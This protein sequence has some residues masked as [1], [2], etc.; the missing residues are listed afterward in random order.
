M[1]K[2]SPKLRPDAAE[3]AYRVMMEATGQ[4]PKT[5]PGQGSKNPEASNR[6][7][8]GGLKGGKGRASTLSEAERKEAARLAATARWKKS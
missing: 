7:R 4:A 3:I 8:K 5:V 2:K 1:A 6:G